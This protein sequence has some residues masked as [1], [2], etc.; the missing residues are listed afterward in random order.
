[1]KG[2]TSTKLRS[3]TELCAY[4]YN[5]YHDTRCALISCRLDKLSLES[6]VE[7]LT[8]RLGDKGLDITFGDDLDVK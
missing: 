7:A 1:M 8:K 5:R 6:I 3:M 4:Y 2:E